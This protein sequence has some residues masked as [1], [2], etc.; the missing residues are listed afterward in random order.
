VSGTLALIGS[1]EFT[2]ALRAVDTLLLTQTSRRRVLVVPTAV[3]PEGPDAVGAVLAAARDHFDRLGASVRIVPVWTRDDACDPAVRSQL[4]GADLI[5]LAGG[6]VGYL[7]DC[8]VDSPFA[9]AMVEAWCSGTP[10]SAASAAA[11]L[12]GTAVYDPEDAQAPARTG[13]SVIDAAVLPHWGHVSSMSA[14]IGRV[15][16]QQPRL[17]TLDEDTAA[18]HHGRTWMT[19]G[20]GGALLAIDHQPLRPLRDDD[21]PPQCPATA[22]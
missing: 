21:L 13:L 11:V 9:E 10:L 16:A 20:A 6:K 22:V 17:L 8:L 12:L 4:A 7:A 3:A 1:G 2:Q 15:R 18:V 5:Y 19:A 14:F